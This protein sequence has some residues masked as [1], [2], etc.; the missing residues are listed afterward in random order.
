MAS[1][2]MT[3]FAAGLLDPERP[4]PPDLRVRDGADLEDRYAIYRNNFTVNAVDALAEVYPVIVRLLGETFFRGMAGE[5]VRE[6][7]PRSP[8][9]LDYGDGFADFL[10]GYAPVADYPYLGDVARLERAR[11]VSTNSADAEP[12]DPAVLISLPPETVAGL[13]IDLHPSVRLIG[14]DWPVISI[15][16]ANTL[17]DEDL[18]R[19]ELPDHGEDALVCRRGMEAEVYFLPAG[20]LAFYR[21][22]ACRRTLGEAAALALEES[23]AF[24]LTKNLQGLLE[25]GALV[26]VETPDLNG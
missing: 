9:I 13:V 20:G 4:V 17:D 18:A 3:P 16:Q 26:G 14:S 15:W 5:Y 23:S 11:I 1:D 8:V 2:F 24:D 7:P 6:N 10:D 22:L 21:S 25:S 12:L 19:R